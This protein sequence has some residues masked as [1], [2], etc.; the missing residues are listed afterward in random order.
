[1]LWNLERRLVARIGRLHYRKN[2]RIL[3]REIRNKYHIYC[4][5]VLFYLYNNI[6]LGPESPIYI[7][8]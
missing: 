8:S 7:H 2:Y 3:G 4:R 1:M 5:S 6:I